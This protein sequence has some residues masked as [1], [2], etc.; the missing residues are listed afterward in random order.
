MSY[1]F[2]GYGTDLS[3]ME[4]VTNF[5]LDVVPAEL[6]SDLLSVNQS[7][8]FLRDFGFRKAIDDLII[9]EDGAGSWLAVLGTPLVD[10]RVREN[11][12]TLVKRF[13]A[14]PSRTIREDIDGCF[15]VLAYQASIDTFYAASDYNNTT[16]VYFAVTPKGTFLSSH[17]LP[18]ARFLHSDLD[19][20]GFSMAIQLMVTWGRHSRFKG[21]HKLLP[22]EMMTFSGKGEGA[23]ERYWLPNEERQW[24]GNFDDSVERWLAL[25]KESVQ[26]YYSNTHNKRVICD[27]TAG[28]DARLILSQCHSLGIPF[29]AMVDGIETDIDVRVAREASRKTG[30]DLEVRPRYLITEDQLLENATYISLMTDASQDYFAACTA[31]A[32]NTANPLKNWESVKLCGAPGGE[33]YRGSYYLRGKAIF[34][35][36]RGN[37]NYRF[38]T[39]MKY[40]L[41]FH[42]QLMNFPDEDFLRTVFEM[43]KE[44]LSDVSDFPNGIKIDHLLRLFQTCSSGLIFKNPRYLPFA[45]K[46]MTSSVYNLRPIHKRGGKLTKACTERLFPELAFIKTQ[47][48]V[49]TVRKTLLRTPLFLPEYLMTARSIAVG[50]ASR[51]LKITESSKP[52]FKWNINAPAIT[53]LLTRPPYSHWFASSESMVTGHLYKSSVVNSLISDARTG[54]TRY[55]PIL[56]RIFNQELACRWVYSER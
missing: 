48:G 41:D 39:R 18:L 20:L 13:F 27:M 3:I 35:S 22:C 44:A 2:S 14:N 4:E 16:P 31:F 46:R 55:V 37:F 21:I 19:P 36:K 50:A 43:S 1:F 12:L 38:F 51:L 23:S 9:L 11:G 17:E 28:E 49:P 5:F 52:G 29:Y 42:P 25:L 7:T 6:R 56:G 26:A 15:A 32:T 54:S 30:F 10:S 8:S 40:L 47:K 34:P 24:T 53:A 45:S 33:A